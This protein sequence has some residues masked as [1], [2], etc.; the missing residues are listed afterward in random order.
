MALNTQMANAT[1]N[2]QGATLATLCNSGLIRVYDGTQPATADTAIAAQVLGV[3]LTFGA[4]AFPAATVGLLTA[5]AITN[6]TAVAAITPTWAR[7]LKSDGTTVVM[8][9]SAGASGCNLT[10]GAFT[11]GTIVSCT[12]FTHDVLNASSG[13]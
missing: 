3:T 4:T 1:V 6:G 11:V 2:A 9:V 10:I 12:S 7:I 5:N 8:D 13:L